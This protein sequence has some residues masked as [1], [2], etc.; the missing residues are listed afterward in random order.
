MLA[1]ADSEDGSCY[2]ET[3]NLDGETNLKI[4]KS[5]EETKHLRDVG[6]AQLAGS[7]QCELPNARW[8]GPC[9]WCRQ[10]CV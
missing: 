1:G 9:A 6:L 3:M 5:V 10:R 8:A 2:V 4:K 7:I